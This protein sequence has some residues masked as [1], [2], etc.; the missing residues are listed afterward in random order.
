[1]ALNKLFTVLVEKFSSDDKHEEVLNFIDTYIA[2][3][4]KQYEKNKQDK[5]LTFGKFA[6]YSVKELSTTVKG[7]SY[8]SWLLSQSWCD[9]EKFGW[10]HEE[11]VK[12]DVKKKTRVSLE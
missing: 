3:E 2:D 12:Y 10:I 8:L 6:G 9:E 1:M 7:K 4:Q 11:C 5:A